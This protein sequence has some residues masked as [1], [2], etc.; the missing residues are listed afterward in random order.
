MRRNGTISLSRVEAIAVLS[1]GVVSVIACLA[2]TGYVF[3]II[4]IA[5]LLLTLLWAD[6]KIAANG[7]LKGKYLFSFLTINTFLL[8]ALFYEALDGQGLLNFGFETI[9]SFG[10]FVILVSVVF[11]SFYKMRETEKAI[12]EHDGVLL[13]AAQTEA[14]NANLRNLTLKAQIKPHFVFNALAAIQRAYLTDFDTGNELLVTFSKLL[15]AVVDSDEKELIHFSEELDNMLDYLTIE[16][17][18]RGSGLEPVLDTEFLDFSVP[19][20]SLQPFLE[21]AAKHSGVLDNEN[22]QL[23]ISSRLSEDGGVVIEI[24]DNGCGFDADTAI[25]TGGVGLKNAKARLK[26][27]LDADVTVAGAQG[28]GTTVRIVIPAASVKYDG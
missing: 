10:C 13:K 20:L 23:Q 24:S 1:A 8:T 28:R 15:R 22:G 25:H 4:P 26:Y 19:A 11:L 16:S 12:A 21:N 9:F 6:C 17:K 5:A 2:L 18:R 3:Q 14:E 7:E 27:A